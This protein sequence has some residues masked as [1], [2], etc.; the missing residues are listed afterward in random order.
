MLNL[1][2]HIGSITTPLDEGLTA[3]CHFT[4]SSVLEQYKPWQAVKANIQ[5]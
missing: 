5:R 1:T 3:A 4:R 2:G